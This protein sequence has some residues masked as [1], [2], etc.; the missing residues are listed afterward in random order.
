[1]TFHTDLMP[2][3]FFFE[4]P[5]LLWLLLDRKNVF[6]SKGQHFATLRRN[7]KRIFPLGF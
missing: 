1:M 2:H 3:F 4:R 6:F 7:L 5:V